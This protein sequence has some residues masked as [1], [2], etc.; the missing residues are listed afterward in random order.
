MK[1]YR[2]Y[3][4]DALEALRA[5]ADESVDLVNTDPPYNVGKKYADWNDQMPEAEYWFWYRLIFQEVHR[6]MRRGYCY[7]SCSQW[8]QQKV[9]DILQ[10]CGFSYLQ[11]LIWHRP[12]FVGRDIR[13]KWKLSYEPI[14]MFSKGKPLPMINQF[15]E[16]F[17]T[18]D[19]LIYTVP[20]SNYVKEERLHVCQKPAGLY[21]HILARTPGQIVLDP[22]MG[23]GTTGVACRRLGKIFVGFDIS[24]SYVEMSR[25][26]IEATHQNEV[27]HVWA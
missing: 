1:N 22:F 16:A 27:L 10:E 23:S 11:T 26:R 24:Q 15:M 20:Q 6:V 25:K 18:H 5:M 13:A 8:Q 7:V 3:Q 14:L 4:V 21:T 2:I 17:P 12:N 9:R 19:V